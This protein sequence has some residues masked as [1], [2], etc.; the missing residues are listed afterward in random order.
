MKLYHPAITLNG[1]RLVYHHLFVSYQHAILASWCIMSMQRMHSHYLRGI[2]R[3]VFR[4]S[5]RR[6]GFEDMA[7]AMD[8]PNQCQILEFRRG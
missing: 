8:L 3:D 4:E 7:R 2:V 5:F 1:E 6:V